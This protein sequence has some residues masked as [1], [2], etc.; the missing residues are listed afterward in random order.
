MG[1]DGD[2]N[3]RAL[4]KKYWHK[5]YLNFKFN[6]TPIDADTTEDLTQT[7]FA[8]VWEK[9]D[10][11]DPER[12]SLYTWACGIAKNVCKK[13]R[14]SVAYKTGDIPPDWDEPD[15]RQSPDEIAIGRVVAEELHWKIQRLPVKLR[16]VFEKKREGGSSL[17]IAHE[18]GIT[19]RTVRKRYR[20]ALEILQNA[21]KEQDEDYDG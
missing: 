17:D 13:Y 14:A 2:K 5:I 18:L 12:A 16:V 10:T 20:K 9:L 6:C 8:I 15:I 1:P 7:V 3:Y 21:L 19:D 4:Y 11:F